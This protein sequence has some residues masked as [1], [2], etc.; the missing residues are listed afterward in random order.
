MDYYVGRIHRMNNAI[1]GE[2]YLK[3]K[4]LWDQNVS[5][6]M[7][8]LPDHPNAESALAALNNKLIVALNR[9]QSTMDKRKHIETLLQEAQPELVA[10][11]LALFGK[12]K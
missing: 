2:I 11:R 7:E 1:V 6:E 3:R 10:N 12:K 4:W 9:L 5:W 8:Y